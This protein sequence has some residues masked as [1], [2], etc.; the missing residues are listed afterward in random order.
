LI[1]GDGRALLTGFGVISVVRGD[2]SLI[3]Q[4]GPRD[5]EHL[6]TTT[7]W[8]APEIL[9]GG[10]VSKEGDIFAFAIVAVEVCT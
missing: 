7:A 6:T 5:Q 2:K 9:R 3:P 4:D 8:A 1:D 10:P